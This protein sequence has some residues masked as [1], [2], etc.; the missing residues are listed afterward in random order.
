MSLPTST[1]EP[2][3]Q[4]TANRRRLRLYTRTRHG[5]LTCRRRKKK[6]DETKPSCVACARNCLDCSWP[7]HRG[8]GRASSKD[9]QDSPLEEAGQGALNPRLE[10]HTQPVSPSTMVSSAEIQCSSPEWTTGDELAHDSVVV[11]HDD[12]GSFLSIRRAAMLLP[13]SKV[14]LSHYLAETSLLLATVPAQNNPFASWVMAIAYNDDLLMHSILA[15]SG[16]H[17]TFKLQGNME[18]QNATSRHYSLV[19][20]TL[21]SVFQ[22]AITLNDPAMIMRLLLMMMILCHYEVCFRLIVRNSV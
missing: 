3:P 13:A 19:L 16:S 22:D 12:L 7:V 4:P 10:N 6:C 18:I 20:R 14:L 21:H 9:K 8:R 17:L 11:W 2:L 15:L 5:C 1:L